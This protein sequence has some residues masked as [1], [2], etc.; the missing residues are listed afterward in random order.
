MTRLRNYFLTGFIVAAPLAI[1]AYI[2][3]SFVGWVD[4]WVKPY[5]PARYNPDSYLPFAVPGFGLIVAVVLITLVGFLT[6]NFIGRSIVSFGEYLL[7]RMPLVRSVYRTLKQILETVLSERSDTFKKVGLIEYPRKDL[8]AIVFIATDARGELQ[9]STGKDGDPTVA[10][11]LPTTP[12]PTSGF[13]LYVPKSQI[14]ELS[15]SVEEGAKLIISAGLLSPDYH[16]KT[17][18][19]AE[20][21]LASKEL[22]RSRSGNGEDSLKV[23]EVTTAAQPARKR[24][25][26]SSLPKR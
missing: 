16:E 22:K 24:R 10:V 17:K 14:I 25:T 3:W 23:P 26:A 21:A 12:N 13:L 9:N 4:S 8:W 15:M 7:E 18:E 19:L 6:A 11:F 5:I 20:D 1:T 2:V